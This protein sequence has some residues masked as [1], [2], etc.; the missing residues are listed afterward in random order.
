[1][2]DEP[3]KTRLTPVQRRMV[4]S[5]VKIATEEAKQ[6]TY[7]H[8]VLCQ[9]CLPYR[10]PGAA[11][12]VWE[13]HQGQVSLSLEAGRVAHPESE[14]FVELG[15]P[16]GT[17]ARL[18]LHYLNAEAIKTSSPIIAV[19]NSLTAFVQRLQGRE[20]TGPEIRKFKEQLSRLAAAT[21]RLA[22]FQ[23]Q[24]AFQVN[25]QIVSAFDLWFPKD[26]NQ[27]VLWPSTVQLSN[28]YFGSLIT[29]AVPLDER[30]IA[31]LA[32]SAMA[33]DVY[34]WL[35]QR[36]HRVKGGQ[37]IPWTALHQQFGQGYKQIRQ[38]R[39]AFLKVLKLVKLAYP[40]AR[41]KANREG[42]LLG[43]SP[44]PIQKRLILIPPPK[45]ER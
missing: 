31:S 25:S 34:C 15:L 13:R 22:V 11:I 4:E 32:H 39:T 18:I 3:T 33:L 6:I 44:P 19:A 1:M 43:N 35:A 23:E 45:P 16:F 14:R 17:K 29:H 5:S 21:I 36:L 12:R 42:L 10:D 41:V 8:T 9:T 20:P 37:F 24:R 2:S 28:E 40:A 30:A 38:F 26:A 7:Q 27:R